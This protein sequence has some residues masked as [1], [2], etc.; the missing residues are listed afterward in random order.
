MS[1]MKVT[2]AENVKPF[3]PKIE[4]AK[5]FMEKIKEYSQS[6][7]TDKFIVSD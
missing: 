1:L 5:E 7:I 6:D 4:D 3:M 2:L